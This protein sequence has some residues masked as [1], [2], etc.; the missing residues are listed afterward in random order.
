MLNKKLSISK[1]FLIVGLVGGLGII[2][3]VGLLSG[4]VGRRNNCIPLVNIQGTTTTNHL[5]TTQKPGDTTQRPGDT[6]QRPG[7]T[8]TM[9]IGKSILIFKSIL[10]YH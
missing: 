1:P 7:Q 8:S 9:I 3:L 6:T 5:A 10:F 4:I 2:L